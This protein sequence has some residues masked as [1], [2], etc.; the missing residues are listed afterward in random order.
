MCDLCTK[1]DLPEVFIGESSDFGMFICIDCLRDMVKNLEETYNI[2]ADIDN[3]EINAATKGSV[4]NKNKIN[5]MSPSKINKI[6][7]RRVIGQDEAKKIVSVGIYNHY[8]RIINGATN[9]KKSNIILVGPTG[10][11]K[12]EIARTVAEILDVPFAIADATSLTEA[13]YVGDDVENVLLK[14]IRNADG[15]IKK[16]ETG[17]IYIDEIDKIA[18]KGENPSITRDVSGEGVQQALLKMIEGATVSV[19]VNGGR[20]HPNGERLEINTENILFICGVAFENLTMNKKDKDVS[21]NHIGF[22]SEAKEEKGERSEKITAKDLIKQGL[23][24]ELVGRLPVIAELKELTADD[25]KRILT[26]P[27]NSLVKQYVDLLSLDNINLQFSDN[28]LTQLATNAYK[29][30]TGARGLKTMMETGLL[31]IMFTAPDEIADKREL[32]Q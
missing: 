20:K 13:G 9:I 5:L 10:V 32:L 27:D 11:G 8:K 29:N 18:R 15:D 14:L 12:T 23:I 16:A 26:E 28:C 25:L 24:P 2:K 30:K 3:K 17:I 1:K 21:S 6:L 7:N 4:D 31:D 22:L 19:P